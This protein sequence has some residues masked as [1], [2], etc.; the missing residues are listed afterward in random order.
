MLFMFTAKSGKFLHSRFERKFTV[1]TSTQEKTAST[2]HDKQFSVIITH[3]YY[4]Y[5][6]IKI[7]EQTLS[8]YA[9]NLHTTTVPL[10]NRVRIAVHLLQIDPEQ[11]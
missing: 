2:V 3:K 8:K 7:Q 10:T 6:T 5:N 1:I 4:W 9:Q 11:R